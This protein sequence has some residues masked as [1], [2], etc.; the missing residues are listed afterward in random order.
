MQIGMTFFSIKMYCLQNESFHL[1]FAYLGFNHIEF[2]RL[3]CCVCEE[4]CPDLQHG[5]CLVVNNMGW[6][7]SDVGSHALQNEAFQL[8]KKRQRFQSLP[9]ERKKERKKHPKMSGISI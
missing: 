9:C 8:L 2:A 3:L 7:M 4:V 1:L 5:G 6:N